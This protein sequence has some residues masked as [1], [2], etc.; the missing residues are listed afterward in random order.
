MQSIILSLPGTDR[1][2]HVVQGANDDLV[3]ADA[4]TEVFNHSRPTPIIQ[5]AARDL[6][7]GG[8]KGFKNLDKLIDHTGLEVSF[9]L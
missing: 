5:A 3:V 1:L 9:V 7:T 2:V 6:A 4:I 8:A